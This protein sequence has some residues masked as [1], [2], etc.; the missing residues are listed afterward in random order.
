M[1]TRERKAKSEK[2]IRG[3]KAEARGAKPEKRGSKRPGEEVQAAVA[4]AA[5]RERAK[6]SG[7]EAVK[8][9]LQVTGG[10]GRTS[11]SATAVCNGYLSGFT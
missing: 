8:L 4:A 7:I 3:S 2:D 5:A 6:R 11:R 10:T 1:K 9:H